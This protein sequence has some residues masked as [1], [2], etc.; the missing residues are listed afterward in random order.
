ML[1]KAAR[2]L[3]APRTHICRSGWP[4]LTTSTLSDDSWRCLKTILTRLRSWRKPSTHPHQSRC[5]ENLCTSRTAA[6]AAQMDRRITRKWKTESPI[7]SGHISNR[8]EVER[9]GNK[10]FIYLFRRTFSTATV[11][12]KSVIAL[13]AR[14]GSIS[15]EHG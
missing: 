3:L 12:A 10:Y 2:Y 6:E 4:C 15:G 13:T 1:T 9:I 11:P 7:E 8:A 14:P 5:K